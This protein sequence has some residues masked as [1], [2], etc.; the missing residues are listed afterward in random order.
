MRKIRFKIQVE[1]DRNLLPGFQGKISVPVYKTKDSAGCDLINNG[2]AARLLPMD[3]VCLPT[4]VHI[5]LP[6]GY[7]GQVRGRSGLN[8]N[9]GIIVPT[10]TIDADYRGE[11]MVVLYNLS[12]EEYT[13]QPGDRIAQLVISP[14]V[15]ANWDEVE[16]LDKTE[17]GENGF[18]STGK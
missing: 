11:I 7:E 5:S 16:F 1:E 18:G 4:G 10:G 3:R 17:R 6:E 9:H 8:K 2:G 12:R 15:Q 14:V 13:I